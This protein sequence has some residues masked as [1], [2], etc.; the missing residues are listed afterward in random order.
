MEL[1]AFQM[2]SL[3]DVLTSACN[4]HNYNTR[5]ECKCV[6]YNTFKKEWKCQLLINHTNLTTAALLEFIADL[7]LV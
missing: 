7:L 5:Y 2:S 4:I 3:I 6:P 1:I